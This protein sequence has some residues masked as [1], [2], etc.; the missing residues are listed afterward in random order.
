MN[1]Q[2]GDEQYDALLLVSFGGPEGM[3]DVMPFLD[4]VLRG[5]NVPLER[6]KAVAEHYYHFAGISP[7]NGQNRKL[8]A[9]LKPELERAAI[10]LPIYWGNR[11]W[12]PMLADTLRQMADDGIRKALAF[13]TA[14]YSSYSSCRQY[15]D[16]IAEARRIVGSRAPQ[17]DKLRAFYNHPGFIEANAD[18]LSQALSK[19]PEKNRKVAQIVFTAHS[20]PLSMALGCAYASQLNE[21][22]RLVVDALGCANRWQLAYQ[23]RSGPPSQPWL[24]P[25]I[26]DCL[27]TSKEE[28]GS[29]II[30]VPIGF[31]SDHMEV[32]YD[33]DTEAKE[34]STVLGINLIRAHTVGTH[35]RFLKTIRELI[36]ERLDPKITKQSLGDSGPAQDYCPASCCPSGQ[37]SPTSQAH[38]N[39]RERS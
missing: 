38:G 18:N 34:L 13:V 1:Q 8:I 33:L 14:A 11:N 37:L 24:A 36:E 25:D 5:R 3:D 6:K 35:P 26:S 30:V 39:Q 4:N 15:Q 32:L 27:R 16:D 31:L 20:I 12:Q 28:G 23:S 17:I 7:I 2:N 21:A 9:A 10:K 29:D 22:S 19:I